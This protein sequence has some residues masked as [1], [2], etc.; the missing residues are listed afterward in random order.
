MRTKAKLQQM[1]N[2]GVTTQPEEM[3]E[4]SGIEETVNHD[5]KGEGRTKKEVISRDAVQCC[6]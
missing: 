4:I 2:N 6:G 5:L 3:N 1:A